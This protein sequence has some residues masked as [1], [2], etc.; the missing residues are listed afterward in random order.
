MRIVSM[1]LVFV[2]FCL[3]AYCSIAEAMMSEMRRPIALLAAFRHLSS[4]GVTMVHLY[5]VGSI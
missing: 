1:T 2:V 4:N 3:F 5:L